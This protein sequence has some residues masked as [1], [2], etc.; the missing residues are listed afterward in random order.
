MNEAEDEEF[1][2]ETVIVE[3]LPKRSKIFAMYVLISGNFK[4][5]EEVVVVLVLMVVI[6]VNLFEVVVEI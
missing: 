2:I 3:K 5:T 1:V 6:V 4:V